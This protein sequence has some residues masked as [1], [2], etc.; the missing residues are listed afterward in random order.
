[1]FKKV[2]FVFGVLC[3]SQS[4]FSNNAYSKDLQTFMDKRD[5]CDH[6]RGESSG[7]LD[8]DNARNLKAEFDKYCTGTDRELKKLKNKYQKII[9]FCNP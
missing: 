2:F 5:Q 7:E 1:M 4:A 6:L 3:F 9:L 8:I